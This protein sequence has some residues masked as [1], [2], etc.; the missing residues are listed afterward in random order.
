MCVEGIRCWGLRLRPRGLERYGVLLSDGHDTR[1][2]GNGVLSSFEGTGG[3]WNVVRE[4]AGLGG[5]LRQ[6]LVPSCP[7]EHELIRVESSINCPLAVLL[8]F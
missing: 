5:E 8:G 1:R 4:C 6:P 3:W 2:V 7:L